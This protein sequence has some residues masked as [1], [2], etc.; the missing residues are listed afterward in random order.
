VTAVV[1]GVRG[2]ITSVAA[3]VV[4]IVLAFTGAALIG[5]QRLILTDNVDEVL[6]R[7]ITAI[8][9]DIDAGRLGTIIPGQGDGE[10]FALVVGTDGNPLASTSQTFGGEDPSPLAGDSRAQNLAAADGTEFRVRS[11]RHGDLVIHAGTPLDDVTEGVA[12]L[13]SGLL[14]AVPAA[15]LLLAV[16]VWVLVG[17]V[18]RPVE[19]IRGQVADITAT[20]LDRR[21]PV[22]ATHDEIARLASTMNEMLARLEASAERQ[23]RFVADASHE[24]RSPLARI[25]SELE[26]DRA[27]PESADADATQRSILEETGNLQRLVDDLLMLAR[28]HGTGE[29]GTAPTGTAP[30]GT[31]PTGTVDLDDLVLA[32]ARRL[33]DSGVS[34]DLA[35]VS[36]AQVPG[37]AAQL[38]RVVRNLFDNAALHGGGRV[39]VT[40]E[41]DDGEAVLAVADRGPGIP[42][43][44]RD[45]VFERFVR[46]DRARTAGRGGS[47]LGLAIVKQIVTDHGGTI[48]VDPD[49]SPGSRFVVR[50]PLR[51]QP[52]S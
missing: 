10:S 1:W 26:V 52:V 8:E 43:V 3:A 46:V 9:H 7:Q 17:R 20:S 13:T 28:G 37:S 2:R 47:G 29:T 50:L 21:V 35:G 16:L 27:H 42:A 40:L 22:P 33:R 11:V 24:L 38:A 30:T 36:G 41:E 34:V 4:L 18:L 51:R 32:E 5:A 45:R 6:E 31:A 15:T 23:E 39:T 12:A 14:V 44:D 19:R 25:R 49:F 48:V